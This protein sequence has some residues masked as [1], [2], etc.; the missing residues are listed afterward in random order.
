MPSTRRLPAEVEPPRAADAPAGQAASLRDGGRP[1][2]LLLALAL[3]LKLVIALAALGSNP[4][5][6]Q[7]AADALYYLERA[8]GLAGLLDDP[9]A[10]ESHHLP[11]L[12]PWVLRLVPGAVQGESFGVLALQAL[13]GTV[14]LAGTWLLARRRLPRPAALLAV[15]LTLLYG[16]LTFY[17]TRL[18]GDSLATVL[19]V[20]LLV[21]CDALH[22]ARGRR[23]R[24]VAGLLAGVL[25]ALAA[26]LRPQ[27]LLLVPVLGL[28]AARRCRRA[29]A[30][31]LV[32]ALLLLLPSTLHNLRAGAGFAPVS[33]NGAINLWIASTGPASGT[34]QAPS[35]AF[36]DIATQARAARELAEQRSGRLLAPAQV[37]AWFTRDALA[38]IAA[39]PGTWLARLG[40][41]A[42]ALVESFETDV[43]AF[44]P[45]EMSLVPPLALLALPFGLLLGLAA[46]A[47]ALGGRLR[48]A[49]RLPALSLAAMVALTALA[50]F[51]YS[52]FRL[53]LAPLLA[54]LA[55]TA[56]EPLRARA[57]TPARGALALVLAAGVVLQSFAPA[58]HQ[59]GTL[60]NG[61]ASVGWARLMQVAPHDSA[62]VER[63]LA[64]A[65]RALELQPVFPR[66]ERLAARACLLLRRFADAGQHLD[67]ALA[68]APDYDEALVDLGLLLAIDDPANPRHD[69]AAALAL[70]PRLQQLAGRSRVLAAGVAEIEALLARPSRN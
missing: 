9:Q 36:G 52:R 17:E 48:A 59:R 6:R 25:A 29:A 49:P 64:D 18:L 3:A 50:F 31:L 35:Q 57:V 4:L 21:A 5:A 41:K 65:C 70:R 58:P 27:A 33:D 42:R 14:L 30:V 28:W 13:A 39:D 2:L 60:A 54:I 44:P 69:R 26:L 38:T 68:A 62:A 47:L 61:W 7:P 15:A 22:D 66:A 1:L 37:S 45:V 16:P 51:H 55:A 32:A 11:P 12:Y 67:A 40:L 46:G 43:A 8:R 24:T 56:W 34:F 63:V 10:D 53:P 19:L 20:L 23:G